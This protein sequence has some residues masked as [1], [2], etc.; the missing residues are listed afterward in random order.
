MKPLSIDQLDEI[1]KI[2]KCLSA[3]ADL[4]LTGKDL[5]LVSREDLALLLGYFTD[6]L[7]AVMEAEQ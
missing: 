7:K 3:I 4:M 5:N 1:I 2:Q 6:K